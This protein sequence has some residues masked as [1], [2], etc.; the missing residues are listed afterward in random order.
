MKE[1]YDGEYQSKSQELEIEGKEQA[2]IQK[3]RMMKLVW[4]LLEREAKQ[5]K[6]GVKGV[7]LDR[8]QSAK[9]VKSSSSQKKKK[10]KVD[11]ETMDRKGDGDEVVVP[12]SSLLSLR[13]KS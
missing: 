10:K 4:A 8:K 12:I 7:T 6:N 5:K 13:K 9:K 2:R 1:E 3:E 11:G